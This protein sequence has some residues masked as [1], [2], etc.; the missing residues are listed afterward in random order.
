M[1]FSNSIDQLQTPVD[2][3]SKIMD[4]ADALA[5]QK[6][7]VLG[8]DQEN[9]LELEISTRFAQ[10]LELVQQTYTV[11]VKDFSVELS[12]FQ[13]SKTIQN[14]HAIQAFRDGNADLADF[15]DIFGD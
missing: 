5:N 2:A 8:F 1:S 10:Q 4:E 6:L 7:S 14:D 15:W 9:I 12:S 11:I 13:P 3:L